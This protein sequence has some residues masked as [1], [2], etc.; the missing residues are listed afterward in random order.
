[1]RQTWQTI[2]FCNCGFF[3]LSALWPP[4]TADADI[5]CYCCGFFFLLFF[6]VSSQQFQIGCLPYFHSIPHM[7]W[8]GLSANEM[9]CTWLAENTGR[10]ICH[11]HTAL[12]CRAVCLQLRHVSTVG[13]ISSVCPRSVVNFGPETAEIDWRVWGTPAN[14]NGFHV[15]A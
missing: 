13:N 11:L 1:V 3:F 10:K 14:F 8:H 2:I 6:L 4:C 12:T 15:W 9:C 7:I 5:P